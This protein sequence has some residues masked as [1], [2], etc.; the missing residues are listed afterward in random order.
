MKQQRYLKNIMP[1]KEI[2]HVRA[3]SGWLSLYK[4][5]KQAKKF[6]GGEKIRTVIPEEVRTE[7][8]WEGA[9]GIFLIWS[10]GNVPYVTV[11]WATHAYV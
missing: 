10:D 8:I 9:W 1:V 6:H 5:L 7:V 4:T 3:Y 2:L 11:V